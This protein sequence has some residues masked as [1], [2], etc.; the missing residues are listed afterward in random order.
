MPPAAA[1][2]GCGRTRRRLR[3]RRRRGGG[4]PVWITAGQ[5][6]AGTAGEIDEVR[7]RRLIDLEIDGVLVNAPGRALA[8]RREETAS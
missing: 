2:P 5:R 6:K 1:S 4:N 7:L 8:L 3:S